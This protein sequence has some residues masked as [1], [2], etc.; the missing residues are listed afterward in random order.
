MNRPV[1]TN[2]QDTSVLLKV[3][4]K[5]KKNVRQ[6]NGPSMSFSFQIHKDKP[7]GPMPGYPSV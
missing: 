1:P 4:E 7:E 5:F 2:T 3:E 6:R